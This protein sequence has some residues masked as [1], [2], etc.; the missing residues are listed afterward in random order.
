MLER[1]T[2]LDEKAPGGLTF[3][4][5]DFMGEIEFRARLAGIQ[6]TWNNCE[7]DCGKDENEGKKILFI[8]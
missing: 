1:S 6:K 2:L 7:C 5:I 8:P 3:V 4:Q